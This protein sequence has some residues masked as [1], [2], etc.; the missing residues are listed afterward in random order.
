MRVSPSCRSTATR[1]PAPL[2]L[3]YIAPEGRSEAGLKLEA[4]YVD[5]QPHG[6]KRS[7]YPDGTLRAEYRYEHGTLVEAQCVD[8]A[9]R[10]ACRMPKHAVWPCADADDDDRY[11]ASFVAIV[12][13]NLPP[14]SRRL[15]TPSRPGARLQ[16]LTGWRYA[17][18]ITDPA[19]SGTGPVCGF[20]TRA[21]P[22]LPPLPSR[23]ALMRS[24]AKL[25]MVAV[26]ARLRVPVHRRVS[27]RGLCH[28]PGPYTD[29]IKPR[30]V[31]P[32]RHD[33]PDDT[34]FF[35]PIHDGN[36][37]SRP[38]PRGDRAA[39]QATTDSSSSP[40]AS[41]TWARIIVPAMPLLIGYVGAFR[42]VATS[43]RRT[44]SARRS[45]RRTAC[46]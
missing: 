17:V 26:A 34:M 14:A 42:V 9:R 35:Y 7:W 8:R 16:K 44:V 46:R 31:Y 6:I 28:R 27:R 1:G 33:L 25:G 30:P 5:D 12:R 2:A 37:R 11:Y 43:P 13:D 10:A 23:E 40:R 24:I 4:P 3:W 36:R 19:A 45:T 39:S 20:W 18:I 41:R 29:E 32:V 21:P 15:R 38:E 22:V